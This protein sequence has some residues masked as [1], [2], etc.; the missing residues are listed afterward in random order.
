[1]LDILGMPIKDYIKK[2][3]K[4]SRIEHNEYGFYWYV[5]AKDYRKYLLVGV[6]G[7]TVVGAYSNSAHLQYRG[8]KPGATKDTVRAV[9]GTP[10]KYIRR[11]NMIHIISEAAQKDYFEAG[12]RYVVVFYDMAKGGGVT[13]IL[14]V[15]KAKETNALIDRPPLDAKA[16]LAYQRISLDLVNSIRIRNGLKKLAADAKNTR[17]ATAR[18]KDM[19]DR[20]YFSHFTPEGLS[21]FDQARKMGIRFKSMGENIAF[22]NHTAIF[23]HEQLMNSAGHRAI[24]LKPSYTK[25]GVGVAYGGT[26]Y[27]IVTQEFTG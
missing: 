9:L 15:P 1:M 2:Y 8:I 24:I 12:D 26:R 7:V 6:A 14:V 18:C 19:R 27:V 13:S 16:Q 5:Y 17:L 4:P 23:C 25:L 11:D 22:G 20:D 3:G 21:P 10:L